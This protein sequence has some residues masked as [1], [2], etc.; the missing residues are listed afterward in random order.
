MT[1]P[2]DPP[3]RVAVVGASGETGRVVARALA[4]RPGTQLLLGARSAERLHAALGPLD[5]AEVRHV[6]VFDDAS[7]ARVC[8][9]ADVVVNCAGPSA[10]IG[11]R[12][13]RAAVARGCHY[14]DPG[15]DEDVVAQLVEDWDEPRRAG[16]AAIFYAGWIPGLSGALARWV[17]EL[18]RERM[19][20]VEAVELFCGDRNVW[21]ETGFA[22]ALSL[23][24]RYPGPLLYEHGEPVTGSLADRGA[25]RRVALPEPLGP[26]LAFVCFMSELREHARSSDARVA[27]YVV[28]LMSPL[29][30]AAMGTGSA[31][32]ERMPGVAARLVRGATARD[33][34]RRPP[35]GVLAASARGEREGR[36]ARLTATVLET[37]HYWVT[38]VVCATAVELLLAGELA[39]PGCRYLCDAAEPGRLI[40]ELRERGLHVHVS[41]GG[42][43]GNGG[44][45]G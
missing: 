9:D 1:A 7:L 25:W 31:L 21:S 30:A 28:P 4:R 16:V 13:A 3:A 23:F 43:N 6:D 40:G 29:T 5:A 36:P 2:E 11:D 17:D 24:A 32:V 10:A 38:G 8:E 33:A 14:V 35:V 19:T 39:A 26:R 42:A 15:G 34:R 41:D 45:G 37:R 22:D 27:S 12:V 44:P 18:A 20:S